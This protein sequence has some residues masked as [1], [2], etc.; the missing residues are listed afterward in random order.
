MGRSEK[1]GRPLSVWARL[2]VTFSEAVWRQDGEVKGNGENPLSCHSQGREGGWGDHPAWAGPLLTLEQ[3]SPPT[4]T[5]I[6]LL[7]PYCTVGAGG[8]SHVYEQLDQPAHLSACPPLP[9]LPTLPLT[10]ATRQAGEEGL[11]ETACTG[12]ASGLTMFAQAW[13]TSC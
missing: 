12:P 7:A 11:K 8:G 10:V 5:R 13:G 6:V 4:T 1:K 9:P 3:Q 2:S